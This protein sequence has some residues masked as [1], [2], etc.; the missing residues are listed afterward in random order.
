MFSKIKNAIPDFI[1]IPINKIRNNRRWERQYNAIINF[2]EN[3]PSLTIEEIEVISHLKKIKGLEVFP[4]DF[5]NELNFSNIKVFFDDEVQL[6]Y[7]IHQ[8]H[9]LY[10]RRGMSEEDVQG[11]YSGLLNEQNEKSPHLYLTQNF[12]IEPGSILTDIGASEGIFTLSNIE[13]VSKAY[14]FEPN[15]QWNEAL[16]CTFRPWS[17]KVIVINKFVSDKNDETNISLDNYF[18]D[19]K[20]DFIKADVEGCELTVLQ[21]ANQIL[22]T[23]NN[24]KISICTYHNQSDFDNI[25]NLLI[26]K[27]QFSIDHSYGYMLFFL[28]NNLI[29]PYLRR[30][31]LR[32]TKR[33]E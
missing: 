20:P 14:L 18:K 27:Y 5:K 4:Y 12:N 7:V 25:S 17:E 22:E 31:I 8:T 13:K 2:Y 6:Y 33:V 10:F 16:D 28:T 19:I 3:K 30:G 9:R 21:G 26:N 1:K 11:V 15:A 32:A 23:S 24:I 29:P